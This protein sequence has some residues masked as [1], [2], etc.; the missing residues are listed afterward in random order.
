MEVVGDWDVG[1]VVVVVGTAMEVVG[2]WDVGV[3]A[4]GLLVVVGVVVDGAAASTAPA[5][6]QAPVSN[7]TT[8]AT[9]P[10]WRALI[11]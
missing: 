2:D 3:V 8:A 5:S 6:P 10:N 9:A 11:V 4:R 1:V 7:I